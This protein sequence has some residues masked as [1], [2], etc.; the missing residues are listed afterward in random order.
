MKI[1]LIILLLIVL[2]PLIGFN[3]TKGA[4]GKYNWPAY[5][6]IQIP[7]SLKSEDA[8]FIENV[9]N[10]EIH[11]RFRTEVQVFKRIYINSEVAAE[12]FSQQELFIGSSGQMSILQARTL[13][14]SGE[15][16]NLHG[17]QIIET[18]SEKKNKYGSERIR[19]IQ[20]VYPNVEVGDVIDMVYE[21]VLDGYIFSDLLYLED[22]IPSLHSR[23]SMNNY[24]QL[25]LTVYRLNDAPPIE[26]KVEYGSQVI[27]WQSTGVKAIKN[28]YFNALPPDHPSL[29]FILFT[30]GQNLDYDTWFR[31]DAEDLPMEYDI[32]SSIEKM[33]IKQGIIQEEDLPFVQL[34]S[35]I[36]YFEN[37][38]IW[39]DDENIAV[40]KTLNH[41]VKDEVNRILFLRYMMKFLKEKDIRYEK[42]FTKSLLKGRF[43]HGFVSLEQL[44]HRFLVIYDHNEQPHFLFPPRGKGQFYYLDEIPYYLEGNQ[45]IALN[46]ERNILQ[47]QAMI[48]IPESETKYNMHSAQIKIQLNKDEVLSNYTRKDKLSGHYSFLTRDR[49]GVIWKEELGI[50]PDSITVAP[51]FNNNMR[52]KAVYPYQVEFNQ[53]ER[54]HAFFQSI[55]DSIGWFDLSSVLPL[56]VYQDDELDADFGDYLVLPFVKKHSIAVFIQNDEQVSIA[57]D[58]QSLELSNDVGTIEVKLY[59]VNDKVVKAKVT[60]ETNKRYLRGKDVG[61]FKDLL[62]K[63]SEVRQKKW[64][65]KM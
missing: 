12:D 16:L 49:L 5:T 26:S 51:T 19:R 64:L 22:E 36:R 28:D 27:N 55:D 25:D 15:V 56:G 7:D 63:Y 8:F 31:I 48:E 62:Q 61:L 21:V 50:A 41:L 65:L 6:P 20:F 29:V 43:E 9:K 14:A 45:S 33:F 17:D 42:G 24:S 13:K 35:A 10:Y 1:K 39:N 47:E 32:F 18:Y 52:T 46:G 3:Q 40:S 38:C 37:A 44:T 60:I 30:G 53:E 58:I 11:E 34:Q 2:F 59:Q 23:I 4:R 54:S 57:E